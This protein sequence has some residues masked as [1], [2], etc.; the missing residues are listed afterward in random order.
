MIAAETTTAT[1]PDPSESTKRP[2]R[3][4]RAEQYVEGPIVA[5][6]LL[7]LPSRSAKSVRSTFRDIGQLCIDYW[8]DGVVTEAQIMSLR[9]NSDR[10]TIWR[11][12]GQLVACGAIL[13]RLDGRY[14]V[15]DFIENNLSAAERERRRKAIR[16]A[17]R[18]RSARHRSRQVATGQTSEGSN[19]R[20]VALTLSASRTPSLRKG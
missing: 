6:L 11:H 1:Q 10:R 9:G 7:N 15:V 14:E 8:I 2:R 20:G 4:R 5:S 16:E 3:Q 18:A 13:R 17:G 12:V 19:Q